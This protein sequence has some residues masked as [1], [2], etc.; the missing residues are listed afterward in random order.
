MA[1]SIMPS[2]QAFFTQTCPFTFEKWVAST[3]WAPTRPADGNT[4]HV[5]SAA[6]W[7]PTI[8]TFSETWARNAIPN[9][10]WTTTSSNTT[11]F[12]RCRQKPGCGRANERRTRTSPGRIPAPI[13]PKF[14]S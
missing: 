7:L 14:E 9:A 10:A 4:P 13:A 1:S 5:L 11:S 3:V 2:N 8:D 6:V 12:A